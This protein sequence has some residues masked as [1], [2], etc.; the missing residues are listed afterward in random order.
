MCV[1]ST[2]TTLF[3]T[4][5]FFTV[6]GRESENNGITHIT[7]YLADDLPG[8]PSEWNCIV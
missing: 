2:D 6:T 1:K 5:V 7:A 3:E 8:V 4:I